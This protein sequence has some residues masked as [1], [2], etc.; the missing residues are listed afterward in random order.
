[1][2]KSTLIKVSE[3]P[4]K[5]FEEFRKHM[6]KA[7][8][9]KSLILETP[10]YV[11]VLYAKDDSLENRIEMSYIFMDK[12]IEIKELTAK[13]A[14]LSLIEEVGTALPGYFNVPVINEYERLYELI[15]RIEKHI[16]G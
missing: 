15:Q 2:A 10:D 6:I 13:E 8:E 9:R 7:R 4:D 5:A 16:K 3:N 11:Y 14:V 1:M 12:L